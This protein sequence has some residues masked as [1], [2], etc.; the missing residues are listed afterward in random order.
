MLDYEKRVDY[1]LILL[2]IIWK[3]KLLR[4]VPLFEEG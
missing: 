4:E 1:Y 3:L 2:K